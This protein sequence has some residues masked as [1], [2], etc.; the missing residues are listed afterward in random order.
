MAVSATQQQQGFAILSGTATANKVLMSGASGAPSWSVPTYPNA[1]A[2]AGKI[3][4]SDGTN[5]LSSTSLWPDTTTA[6][7]IL[8]SSAANT[9]A[10]ITTAN[11]GVLVTSA[12]G[13]P[14][15]RN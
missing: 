10:G 8:Y 15:Y 14:V 9:I 5:F 13:V 11:N 12:G 2:T 4:R 3:I 1:S 7:Q 6:N